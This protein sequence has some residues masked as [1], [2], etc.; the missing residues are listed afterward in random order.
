MFTAWSASGRACGRSAGTE[1]CSWRASAAVT[2]ASVVVPVP[3][4]AWRAAS[5]TATRSARGMAKRASMLS[6]PKRHRTEEVGLAARCGLGPCGVEQFPRVDGVA[7][8]QSQIRL[9]GEQADKVA[10]GQPLAGGGDCGPQPGEVAGG[11]DE[12][13]PRGVGAGGGVRPGHRGCGAGP[14]MAAVKW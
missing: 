7:G 8:A 11:L 14:G 6:R 2:F 4:R 1:C 12:G 3:Y 5:S 9:G 10:V 13:E